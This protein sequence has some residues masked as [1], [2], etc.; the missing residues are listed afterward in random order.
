MSRQVPHHPLTISELKLAQV[1]IL[2]TNPSCAQEATKAL[3]GFAMA[4]GL[5]LLEL[6]TLRFSCSGCDRRE[7]V[8]SID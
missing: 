2:C 5:T 7:T 8:L 6:R 4:G 1:R 3:N